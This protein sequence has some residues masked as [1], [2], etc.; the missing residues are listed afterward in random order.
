M[1]RNR[2]V[3]FFYHEA[4]DVPNLYPINVVL[5]KGKNGLGIFADVRTEHR[6]T[7]ARLRDHIDDGLREP[8][9]KKNVVRTRSRTTIYVWFFVREHYYIIDCPLNILVLQFII[10]NDRDSIDRIPIVNFVSFRF[11]RKFENVDARVN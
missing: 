9:K 1:F 2:P 5:S 3:F 10:T 7:D 8:D 4:R 6:H 11:F